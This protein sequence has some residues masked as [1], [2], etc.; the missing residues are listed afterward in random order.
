M[1]WYRVPSVTGFLSIPGPPHK[2]LYILVS[3]V[4][5]CTFLLSEKTMVVLLLGASNFCSETW[6][7]HILA[8]PHCVV[9]LPVTIFIETLLFSQAFPSL[10]KLF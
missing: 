5:L 6:Y 9:L 4:T 3:K 8:L 2:P 7:F 1:D 10:N